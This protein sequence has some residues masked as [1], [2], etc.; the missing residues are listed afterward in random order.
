MAP[1][2]FRSEFSPQNFGLGNF[3]CMRANVACRVSEWVVRVAA[4]CSLPLIALQ[5]KARCDLLEMSQNR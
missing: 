2:D 1:A 4:V 5:I 3:T